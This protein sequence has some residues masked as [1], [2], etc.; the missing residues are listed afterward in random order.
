MKKDLVILLFIF[1]RNFL[2]FYLSS[3]FVFNVYFLICHFEYFLEVYFNAI[4]LWFALNNANDILIHTNIAIMSFK[5]S[6]TMV[7]STPS[8]HDSVTKQ[9][10]YIVRQ[11]G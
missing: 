8:L 3:L 4:F 10:L 9:F 1:C 11:S 7:H 5:V 2:S 6:Q